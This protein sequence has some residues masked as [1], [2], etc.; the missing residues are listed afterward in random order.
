MSSANLNLSNNNI[1]YLRN[2]KP[3]QVKKN[4][5][6]NDTILPNTPSIVMDEFSDSDSSHSEDHKDYKIYNFNYDNGSESSSLHLSLGSKNNGKDY[7]SRSHS[8][9]TRSTVGPNHRSQS[10]GRSQSSRHRSISRGRLS[11]RRRSLSYGYNSSRSRGRSLRS[12]RSRSL[13]REIGRAHV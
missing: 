6:N 12:R 1:S 13:S 4:Y 5:N 11:Q 2:S 10:R 8:R 9:S 7:L 3:K